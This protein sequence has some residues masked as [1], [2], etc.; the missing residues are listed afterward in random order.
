MLVAGQPACRRSL[1]LRGEYIG[2]VFGEA[3]HHVHSPQCQHIKGDVGPHCEHFEFESANTAAKMPS[4][5]SQLRST[6]LGEMG[7]SQSPS[8]DPGRLHATES[9]DPL[10]CTPIR[11]KRCAIA[12]PGRMR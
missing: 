11:L 4:S 2:L 12:D 3:E 1:K 10:F 8:Q 5:I 6:I 9:A 7:P